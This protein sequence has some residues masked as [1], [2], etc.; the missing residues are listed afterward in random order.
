MNTINNLFV[1][2]TLAPGRP[3]EHILQDIGG[4]WKEGSVTGKLHQE[5]WELRWATLQLFSIK[6]V[7]RLK[8][9]YLAL[10]NSLLIGMN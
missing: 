9:S 8:A 3:N 4:T 7:K 6:M 1:Y 5:G 2:G 10:K